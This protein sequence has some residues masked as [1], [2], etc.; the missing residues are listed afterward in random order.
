VFLVFSATLVTALVAAAVSLSAMLVQASFRVEEL[1]ARVT[2]LADQGELLTIEV[3]E[4][5]SPS[6][7]ASWADGM[8]MVTPEEVVPLTVRAENRA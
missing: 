5:S 7:V 2:E 8:G 3:A 4:L 1:Q 6:R